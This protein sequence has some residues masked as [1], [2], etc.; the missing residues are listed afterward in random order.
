MKK[1]LFTI[2]FTSVLINVYSQALKKVDGSYDLSGFLNFATGH[3]TYFYKEGKDYERVREG[4]FDYKCQMNASQL[5]MRIGSKLS[6]SITGKYKNGLKDG[7]WNSTILLLANGDGSSIATKVNYKEGLPNGIW[8]S[9][10]MNVGG[11]LIDDVSA[12]FNMGIMVG[13]FKYVHGTKRYEGTSDK[14]GFLDGKFSVLT[15]DIETIFNY[16]HGVQKSII[17]R[18]IKSGELIDKIENDSNAVKKLIAYQIADSATKATIKQSGLKVNYKLIN[19]SALGYKGNSINI[20]D[21][22]NEIF[23]TS[24][25]FKSISGDVLYEDPGYTGRKSVINWRAFL[26]CLEEK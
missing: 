17:L 8:T 14:E 19:I 22:F 12:K 25:C 2:I 16:V 5:R 21:D 15:D 11:Q 18:N 26:V 3:A 4:L 6:V 9:K 24:L 20:D 13:P 1:I 7:E 10:Q 23:N